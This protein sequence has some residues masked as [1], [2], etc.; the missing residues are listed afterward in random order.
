MG[1]V[2]VFREKA[3]QSV[4]SAV[5]TAVHSW[6]ASACSSIS[7]SS[8]CRREPSTLPEGGD[9]N[10]HHCCGAFRLSHVT[11]V[12]AF[13]TTFWKLTSA[14]LVFNLPSVFLVFSFIRTMSYNPS[15]RRRDL[16]YLASLSGPSL[17]RW[18]AI[19]SASV[20]EMVLWRARGDCAA[21]RK[22]DSRR[23]VAVQAEANMI[24]NN[25]NRKP[26]LSI[27][28]ATLIRKQRLAASN[29]L[30][31]RGAGSGKGQGPSASSSS[32]GFGAVGGPGVTMRS[33]RVKFAKDMTPV[34]R[35]RGG[36]GGVL[37][38]T[39]AAGAATRWSCRR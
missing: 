39:L 24:S 32:R 15:G 2:R 11:V 34:R 23:K 18:A 19:L 38:Q 29:T 20:R 4:S 22:A 5:F 7:C 30:H 28:A 35:K 1:V 14:T 36:R 25:I 37:V 12:S 17:R 16:S 3:R 8:P 26:P 10:N 21:A 9:A 27:Q 6:H 31:P 13:S 33:V